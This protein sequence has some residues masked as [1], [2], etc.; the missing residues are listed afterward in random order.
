MRSVSLSLG[1]LWFAWHVLAPP[2]AA[3]EPADSGSPASEAV[4]E[5]AASFSEVFEQ[6]KEMLG[7]LREIQQRYHDAGQSQRARIR[8]EFDQQIE[9]ARDLEAK[10]R[11]AAIAEY[12]RAPS[13]DPQLTKFLVSVLNYDIFKDRLEPALELA[14][15]LLEAGC[16]DPSVND[17][18]G[19]AA[20]ANNDF[21]AAEQYLQAADEAAAL[22]TEGRG[23]LNSLAECRQAWE[24]ELKVRAQEAAADDLPRVKLQTSQ[25]DLVLEL[26]E[27]EAPQTVGNFVNLVESGFYD[28]L[29]FHRVLPG[30]MAQGGCPKGD[31][32]GGPGYSIY[33]ECN[34]PNH[35]KHFRG[36]LSMAKSEAVNTGGSQFFVTFS[37]TPHLDGK[38]TVF[39]RVLEGM[40]V[41]SKLQRRDP[42]GQQAPADVEPDKIIS[43]EVL[44]KRDHEYLPTKVTD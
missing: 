31:G 19:R 9:K 24:N 14:N 18:A 32:T 38:H 21:A 11:A 20:F 10:V 42:T 37:P 30:F 2:S 5:E 17:S 41:L 35:R 1:I 4:T 8:V 27:N 13:E 28:G 26:F 23:C 34:Q 44:R 7:E 25:G 12:Q 3:Q 39:G 29:T 15:L 43:A 16:D 6:W 40:D 36:S 22:T 33:C